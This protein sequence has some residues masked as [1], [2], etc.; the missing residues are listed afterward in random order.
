MRFVVKFKS[1]DSPTTK[2]YPHA[3]LVQDNWDDYGYKT[4]FHVTLHLSAEE[5]YDLGSIKV[6]QIDRTKGYTEMP[7]RPFLELPVGH[8]SMGSDLNYYETVYKLGRDVFEPYFK[9]LRDVAFNDEIKAGIVVAD[10]KLTQLK[11]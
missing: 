6:I 5:N 4:T 7:R 9:G 2:H 11:A 1:G 3:V 8:A 10:R